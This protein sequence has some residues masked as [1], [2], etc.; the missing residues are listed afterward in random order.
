MKKL[1]SVWMVTKYLVVELSN[2]RY[3]YIFILLFFYH[4]ISGFSFPGWEAFCLT[5]FE[6]NEFRPVPSIKIDRNNMKSFKFR[7]ISL[8][9]E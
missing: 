2:M 8:N 3:D 4:C 7:C 1:N 9:E 5:L 6:E